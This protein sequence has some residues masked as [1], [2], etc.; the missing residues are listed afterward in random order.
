MATEA[1]NGPTIR[2]I[3]FGPQISRAELYTELNIGGRDFNFRAAGA[4]S[5]A[6]ES[7]SV[8]ENRTT[9]VFNLTCDLTYFG[10]EHPDLG[11]IHVFQDPRIVN[12]GWIH[13]RRNAK[14]EFET[15][16]LSYFNQ[17]LIFHVGDNYLYYPRAW[18]VV[19]AISVW[20]PEHH[21][22]HHLEDKT[23]IFDLLTRKP[24]VAVKGVSTI[25]I[26]SKLPP[27]EEKQIRDL[28]A[29]EIEQFEKLPA[30]KL[31]PEDLTP[32]QASYD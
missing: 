5:C 15:P 22:Y 7:S 30:S 27:D 32:A 20:P 23:P 29:K 16:A 21:Q 25:S 10:V 26:F 4:R 12:K 8:V 9:L 19:S 31:A 3:P 1:N 18:Q 6:V 14:G 17:H 2:G 13:A 11:S 24:N 28:C